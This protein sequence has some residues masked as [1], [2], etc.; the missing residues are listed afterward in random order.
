M[1]QSMRRGRASDANRAILKAAEHFQGLPEGFRWSD[2]LRLAK[3]NGRKIGLSAAAIAHYEFL[4]LW[5]KDRDWTEPGEKPIVFLEVWGTAAKR[6]LSEARVRQLEYELNEAGL[7]TW[8]DSGNY[9]RG[10]MR[11]SDDGRILF[12][13][14]VDLSPGAA[15]L[16]HLQEADAR[17]RAQLAERKR[18]RTR[19]TNL[20]GSVRPLLAR[21][22]EDALI[23]GNSAEWQNAAGMLSARIPANTPLERLKK[24]AEIMERLRNRLSGI[25]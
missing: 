6:E 2:I 3:D 5:T 21:A 13:H 7:L 10:G 1:T 19:I 15:L 23:D 14:G 20:K 9:H 11:D 12:A 17:R 25:V 4:I 24:T 16:P 8:T 22:I 18:L